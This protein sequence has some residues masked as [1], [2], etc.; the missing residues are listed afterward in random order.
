MQELNI[1]EMLS[2]QG[3]RQVQVVK[4]NL[5]HAFN[6]ALNDIEANHSGGITIIAGN[7]NVSQ[8]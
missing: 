5:N 2:L 6:H 8:S 3:G 7:I 4:G 1:E